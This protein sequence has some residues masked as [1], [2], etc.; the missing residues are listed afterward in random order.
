VY[1]RAL[2][3]ALQQVELHYEIERKFSLEFDGESIGDFR[4]DLVVENDVLVELKAIVGRMPKVHTAQVVSYLKASKLPVGLLV[5]FGN[6]SCDVK[7]FDL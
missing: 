1:A 6:R 3:W 4:A 5:N 2:K 7:R